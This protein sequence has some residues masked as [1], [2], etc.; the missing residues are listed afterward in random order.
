MRHRPAEAAPRSHSSDS[1]AG[2]R[3][4]RRSSLAKAL[5]AAKKVNCHDVTKSTVRLG[6]DAQ[7]RAAS[8]PKQDRPMD[9]VLCPG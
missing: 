2:G 8:L 5:A 7:P 9:E 3:P 6:R 1:S 4:L